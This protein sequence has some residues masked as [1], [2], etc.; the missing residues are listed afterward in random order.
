MLFYKAFFLFFML[1]VLCGGCTKQ[2]QRQQGITIKEGALT[3]GVEIGYPPMEYYD[4]NGQTLI[5]FDI[6]LTKALAERLGLRVEYVDVAWEGILAGLNTNRYDIAINITILPERQ[7]KYNF[8]E[9][10]IDSSITIVALKGPRFKIERPEDIAGHSV[11]YQSDTTAQYFT[12]RL[13]GQGISFTSYS[14]DK[15][16]NCFDDLTLGRVDLIVVD[17]IVAFDYAG[18]EDSPFEVIWQGHSD[19]YIGIC[20]KKGN[21]ILTNALNNALDDLFENGAMAQ[22]SQK[23]FNRDLVSSVRQAQKLSDVD[24]MEISTKRRGRVK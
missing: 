14:Y 3:V 7:N 23:T 9:P 12:E 1:S 24:A 2:S 6:D 13:S 20:L 21:D 22:I 4:A 5:G 18:K 15:I 10:Y 17:N 19:E 8:T 11:C 16:L